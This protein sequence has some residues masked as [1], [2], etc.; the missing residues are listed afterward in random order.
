MAVLA[1]M[2]DELAAQES[3]PPSPIPALAGTLGKNR[4]STYL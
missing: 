3:K 2:S 1:A 4:T